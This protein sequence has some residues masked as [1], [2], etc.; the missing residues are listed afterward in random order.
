MINT[1]VLLKPVMPEKAGQVLD[2]LGVTGSGLAWGGLKS[3]VKL[4]AHPALFPRIE[5]EKA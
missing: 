1:S 4:Q 3:G 2:I 5:L